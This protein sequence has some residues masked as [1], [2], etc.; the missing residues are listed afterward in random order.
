MLCHYDE[1]CVLFIVMLNAIY[2]YA[3]CHY[4]V[5]RY[6]ECHY[7]ECCYAECLHVECCGAQLLFCIYALD[8]FAIS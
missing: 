7:T 4:A 1:S 5:C 8:K 6:A 2:C 3:E